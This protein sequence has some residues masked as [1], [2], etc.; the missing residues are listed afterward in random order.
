MEAYHKRS[1]FRKTETFR[2]WLYRIV[3]NR[4]IDRLR[5]TRHS[6]QSVLL[7][8]DLAD[9]STGPEDEVLR[10]ERHRAIDM[11][12][13]QLP[14]KHRA[15]LVLRYIDDLS[16]EEIASATE[17]PLGTVKTHLFRARTE[18]KRK[19]KVEDVD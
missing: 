19:L 14:P 2:P 13:S 9:N 4:C 3:V 15:V 16:Y 10:R 7:A 18:L 17:L 6:P 11:A 8:S 12:V 5:K 1:T